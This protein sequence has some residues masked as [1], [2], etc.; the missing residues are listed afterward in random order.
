MTELRWVEKL[1]CE[2][3][4][5]SLA[6]RADLQKHQLEKH[7]QAAQIAPQA[8]PIDIG[9]PQPDP[10]VQPVD[11]PAPQSPAA[12]PPAPHKMPLKFHLLIL[13]PLKL[14]LKFQLLSFLPHKLPLKF[15]LLSLLPQKYTSYFIYE[16]KSAWDA[17][18]CILCMPE[19]LCP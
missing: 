8:Q 9:S 2:E 3:C 10:Q 7:A 12:E 15:K 19:V 11:P 4:T 18:S 14:T 6:R 17:A 16:K 5:K 13:L 1:P